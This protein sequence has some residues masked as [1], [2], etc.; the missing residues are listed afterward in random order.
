MEIQD[1]ELKNFSVAFDTKYTEKDLQS[2]DMFIGGFGATWNID[3]END[4]FDPH[5]FDETIQNDFIGAIARKGSPDIRFCREHDKL[6]VIGRL[7][8]LEAR[9]EGLWFKAR[10]SKTQMGTETHILCADR[11]VDRISVGFT[12]IDFH[13]EGSVRVITK[14]RL[15]EL[16]VVLFPAQEDTQ[17]TLVKN[18]KIEMEIEVNKLNKFF[19]ELAEE[20]QDLLL[21]R[22]EKMMSD[23][24]DNAA[25]TDNQDMKKCAMCMKDMA[26]DSNYC[27]GCGQNQCDET[28][29]EE[30]MDLEMCAADEP[31][32]EVKSDMETCSACGQPM[33]TKAA[34]G[35]L[36]PTET[37]RV[38]EDPGASM[39]GEGA[40][41]SVEDNLN[42]DLSDDW[43]TI[44]ELLLETCK[45]IE[46]N[47]LLY[48]TLKIV[49]E[50]K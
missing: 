36:L 27:P 47:D 38:L 50:Y 21:T 26:S 22:L 5:A 46:L 7:V 25:V 2:G 28:P 24:Q 20:K 23:I 18:K 11:A 45:S 14:A 19:N 3:T 4:R 29:A 12:I 37:E 8:E 40:T 16:S 33:P 34:H 39:N 31:V 42:E 35:E 48:S 10:I 41:K 1:K 13:Y 30:V 9:P 32:E 43:K 44:E 6:Y 15:F 49:E 17:I